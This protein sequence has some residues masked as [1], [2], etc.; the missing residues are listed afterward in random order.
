MILYEFICFMGWQGGTIHQA[1]EEFSKMDIAD[2]DRF[3]GR[4]NQ[5]IPQMN[6]NELQDAKWFYDKRNEYLE[7]KPIS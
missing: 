4:L 2:Q 1:R 6:G 3:C 7:I 5:L